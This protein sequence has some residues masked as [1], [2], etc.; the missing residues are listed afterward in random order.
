MIL[1]HIAAVQLIKVRAEAM[2]LASEQLPGGMV[3]VLFSAESRLGLSCDTAKEYCKKRGVIG[4]ECRVAS[5]LGP[6]CKVV[7]GSEEVCVR[8]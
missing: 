8:V 2:Q 6:N 1:A 5:Y 7:G 4:A 3:T